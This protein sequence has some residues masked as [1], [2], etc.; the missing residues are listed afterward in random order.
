MAEGVAKRNKLLSCLHQ[1]LHPGTRDLDPL[2][3]DRA[4]PWWTLGKI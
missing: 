2:G 4:W 1:M 3:P